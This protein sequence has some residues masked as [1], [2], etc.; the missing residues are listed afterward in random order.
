MEAIYTVSELLGDDLLHDLQVT[1]VVAEPADSLALG[2]AHLEFR[3]RVQIVSALLHHA[4][5]DHGQLVLAGLGDCLLQHIPLPQPGA[6]EQQL[7]IVIGV[8]AVSRPDH[9]ILAVGLHTAA[10]HLLPIE[11]GAVAAVI[12]VAIAELRPGRAD[13][14]AHE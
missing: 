11:A 10:H 5:G 3:V 13:L 9:H 1:G 8:V 2:I 14:H 12:R 6:L 7:R 4:I